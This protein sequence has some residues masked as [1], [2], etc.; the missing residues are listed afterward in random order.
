MSNRYILLLV[1]IVAVAL[2]VIA[3]MLNNEYL[4]TCP[5]HWLTGLDCPFCGGQRMIAALL[6]AE[7]GAAF[8][9]NRVLMLFL[10]LL[11]LLGV[12]LLFPQYAKRHPRLMLACLFTDRALVIY[13]IIFAVWGVVRNIFL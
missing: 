2:F 7:W 13:L 12:R 1:C 3:V 8:G 6:R 9:Y 10:P 11:F 5:F 4:F